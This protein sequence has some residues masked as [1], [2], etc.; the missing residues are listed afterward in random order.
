MRSTFLFFEDWQ[1]QKFTQAINIKLESY[2]NL[3]VSI[4]MVEALIHKQMDLVKQ[5]HDCVV[6][7]QGT[8]ACNMEKNK[9][10]TMT[11]TCYGEG[12]F[13]PVKYSS[14]VPTSNSELGLLRG[15]RHSKGQ[16][17]RTVL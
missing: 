15:T 5:T 16:S 9:E 12:V 7:L 6:T 2:L 10:Y 3:G 13:F 11:Q 17:T 14:R 4:A 1:V 8:A